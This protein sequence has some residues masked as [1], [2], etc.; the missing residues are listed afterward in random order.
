M[1]Q[2]S[3]ISE[4]AGRP[5]RPGVSGSDF[6]RHAQA[7]RAEG[8]PR[9]SEDQQAPQGRAAGL[10]LNLTAE[11]LNDLAFAVLCQVEDL[12]DGREADEPEVRQAV[13]RL[14]E[15]LRMCNELKNGRPA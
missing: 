6:G 14:N 10:T 9:P 5:T 11:Q 7:V 8:D 4:T 1:N 12:Q 3:Q 15:V 13:Q 2:N